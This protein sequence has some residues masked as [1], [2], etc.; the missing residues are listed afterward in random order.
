[1]M[2]SQMMFSIRSTYSFP[3][4]QFLCCWLT[5]DQISMNIINKNPSHRRPDLDQVSIRII[6]SYNL[7]SPAMS[8]EPVYILNL[9]KII[10]KFV[11]KTLD[12]PFLKIKLRGIVLRNNFPSQELF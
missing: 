2:T 12:I 3:D 10:L 4:E 9:R 6:E 8:H 1:M 7:L 5:F 11:N